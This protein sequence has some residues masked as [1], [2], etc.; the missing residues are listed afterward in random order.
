MNESAET[1]RE[2]FNRLFLP[3]G[4]QVRMDAERL[5]DLRHRVV[6]LMASIATF[7]FRFGA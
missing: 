5:R 2:M 1:A 3:E 4:K 6:P 7:A